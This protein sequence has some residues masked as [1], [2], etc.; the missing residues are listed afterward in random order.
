M[1]MRRAVLITRQA[2]SPRLAIRI[3]LNIAPLREKR[4]AFLQLPFL[5]ER[6]KRVNSLGQSAIRL[7][8]PPASRTD[9]DLPPSV[10]QSRAG[11]V[12][13]ISRPDIRPR[14]RGS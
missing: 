2:I 11:E 12:T 3:V 9:F 1:P 7:Q 8:G 4:L 10:L 5:L 14:E 13:A 6:Q